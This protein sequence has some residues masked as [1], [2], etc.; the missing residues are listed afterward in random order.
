MDILCSECGGKVD[1]MSIRKNEKDCVEVVFICPY[2]GEGKTE[3][4]YLY[5]N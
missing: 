2:C 1:I 5:G 4:H 3:R